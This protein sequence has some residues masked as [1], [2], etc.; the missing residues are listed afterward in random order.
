MNAFYKSGPVLIKAYDM[1]YD[2]QIKSNCDI[3]PETWCSTWSDNKTGS[4]KNAIRRHCEINNVIFYD[5]NNFLT[6]CK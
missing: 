6:I 3:Q 4:L 2:W 5:D 1:G